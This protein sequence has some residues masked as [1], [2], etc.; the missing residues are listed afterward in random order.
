[1]MM[2]SIVSCCYDATVVAA[3]VFAWGEVVIHLA[4]S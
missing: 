1:M 2:I 3:A 4:V